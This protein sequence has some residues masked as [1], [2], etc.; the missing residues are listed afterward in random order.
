[1][2]VP[3]VSPWQ[4]H[5]V[6]Y[7]Q[8]RRTLAAGDWRRWPEAAQQLMLQHFVETVMARQNARQQMVMMA[9]AAAG[10]LPPQ[11]PESEPGE[12]EQQPAAEDLPPD[13]EM[14][15]GDEGDPQLDGLDGLE[16]GDP[17][18]MAAA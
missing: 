5:E 12:E 15:M 8:H 1:M 16:L 4:N 9:A 18:M 3:Q 17:S 6:H 2:E 10:K 7:R 11:A 13:A 14:G